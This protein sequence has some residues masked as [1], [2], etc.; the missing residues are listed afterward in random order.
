L[1]GGGDRTHAGKIR[2]RQ[3]FSAHHH[4]KGTG[5]CRRTGRD[6]SPQREGKSEITAVPESHKKRERPASGLARKKEKGGG[7]ASEE[8]SDDSSLISSL[9]E[10]KGRSGEKAVDFLERLTYLPKK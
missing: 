9:E 3:S 4:T 5:R 1:V 2:N 8:G 6:Q 7:K 10:K